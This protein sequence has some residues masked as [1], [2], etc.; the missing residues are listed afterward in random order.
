MVHAEVFNFQ[1]PLRDLTYIMLD[2][3]EREFT[4]QF[5][6]ARYMDEEDYD[7]ITLWDNSVM[8]VY[9]N[10]VMA[11]TLDSYLIWKPYNP[12]DPEF[13]TQLRTAMITSIR[14]IERVRNT[15]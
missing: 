13:F 15:D 9:S 7:T 8:H 1:V 5:K 6:A 3:L 2:W 4:Y 11:G 12:A 14:I 10:E